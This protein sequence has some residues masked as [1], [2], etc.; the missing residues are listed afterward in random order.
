MATLHSCS[1][2]RI[3]R[4][5]RGCRSRCPTNS[6]VSLQIRHQVTNTSVS[7]VCNLA[8]ATTTL[9]RFRAQPQVLGGFGF[10]HDFIHGQEV[11]PKRKSQNW[12]DCNCGLSAFIHAFPREV[13]GESNKAEAAPR[14]LEID[15]GGPESAKM[16]IDRTKSI[17]RARGWARR[18]FATSEAKEGEIIVFSGTAPYRISLRLERG[19]P[20]FKT[21]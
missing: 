7:N 15:R 20:P 13:I 4:R 14:Q 19:K 1:I 17:F 2:L 6:K 12:F 11:R 16:D 5:R 9:Q 10:C 3:L 18:F 8:I 21:P